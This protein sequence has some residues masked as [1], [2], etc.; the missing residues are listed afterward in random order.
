MVVIAKTRK[1]PPGQLL[2]G[3]QRLLEQLGVRL[4]LHGQEIAGEHHEIGA[5]VDGALAN[6]R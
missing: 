4:R 3:G 6:A 2:E 5:L 1:N